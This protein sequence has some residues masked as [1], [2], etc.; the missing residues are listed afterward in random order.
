MSESFAGLLFVMSLALALVVV[1][2]P[3]G[4]LMYLDCHLTAEPGAGA[5]GIPAGRS[6]S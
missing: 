2:R 6:R 5:V 4:D 1:H 3:L